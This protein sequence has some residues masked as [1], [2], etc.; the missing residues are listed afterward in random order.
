[1]IAKYSEP[2]AWISVYVLVT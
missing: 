1:V 2:K